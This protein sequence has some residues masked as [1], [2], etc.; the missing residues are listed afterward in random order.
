MTGLA[1]RKTEG[2]RR[3]VVLFIVRRDYFSTNSNNQRTLRFNNL[4]E[5]Q[6]GVTA[7]TFVPRGTFRPTPA[8]IEQLS[9]EA[10]I[11]PK[12]TALLESIEAEEENADAVLRQIADRVTLEATV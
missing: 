6:T 9:R 4:Q 3:D 12:D 8:C 5:L 7:V 10:L 11:Q 2:P 1:G